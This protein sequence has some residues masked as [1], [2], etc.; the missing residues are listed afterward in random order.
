M[1][2]LITDLQLT[3]KTMLKKS[4]MALRPIGPLVGLDRKSSTKDISKTP[5]KRKRSSY[6]VQYLTCQTIPN[7]LQ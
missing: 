6:K 1:R 2:T 4:S 3:L 7:M 5:I